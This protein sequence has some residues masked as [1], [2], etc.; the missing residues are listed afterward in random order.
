MTTPKKERKFLK[1]LLSLIFDTIGLISYI[2]PWFA[3]VSDIIWAPFAAFI[4]V[5]MYKGTL[6]K[7]GA[8]ICLIEE[9]LPSTDF[10]PTFTLMWLY[11]FVINPK[12]DAEKTIDVT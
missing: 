6:G 9:I 8:A 5:K 1:L 7:V 11:K 3:E 2:I 10:I 12:K 4:I